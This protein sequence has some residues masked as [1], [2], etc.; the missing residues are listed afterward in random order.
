V[1]IQPRRHTMN[2]ADERPLAASDHAEAD[3]VDPGV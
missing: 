2:G 1:V 3:A